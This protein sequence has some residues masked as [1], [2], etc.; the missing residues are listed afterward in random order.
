MLGTTKDLNNND[1]T[2]IVDWIGGTDKLVTFGAA[3]I[4]VKDATREVVLQNNTLDEWIT[5][6]GTL[7][8]SI[9]VGSM[10]RVKN[11]SSDRYSTLICKERD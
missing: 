7:W 5:A 6:H 1:V 3:G 8:R 9:P 2:G 10:I 11:Y 4:I